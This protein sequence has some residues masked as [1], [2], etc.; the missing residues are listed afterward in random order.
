MDELRNPD[1]SFMT[2]KSNL[3]KYYIPATLTVF[4]V[5]DFHRR[6]NQ[7]VLSVTV[8]D[9]LTVRIYAVSSYL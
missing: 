2:F 1:I 3:F 8:P 6:G 5:I 9:N 4:D 7:L